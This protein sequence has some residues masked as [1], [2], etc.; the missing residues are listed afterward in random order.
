M[1]LYPANASVAT[2]PTIRAIVY[3]FL[4]SMILSLRRNED[5]REYIDYLS[6][7]AK[8]SSTEV[9]Y[10]QFRDS[11]CIAD[12]QFVQHVTDFVVANYKVF[13]PYIGSLFGKKAPP[14]Q[15]MQLK[16]TLSFVRL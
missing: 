10:Y 8:N 11:K 7:F 1:F 15:L 16:A 6:I 5:V 14:S 12:K 2:K 3:R 4:A 9:E 13:I